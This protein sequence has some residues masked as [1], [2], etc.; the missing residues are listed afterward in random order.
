MGVVVLGAVE[1]VD[2]TGAVIGSITMA[3]TRLALRLLSVHDE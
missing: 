3:W 2:D 1:I